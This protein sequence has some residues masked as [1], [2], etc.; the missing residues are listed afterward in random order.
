MQKIKEFF[1]TLLGFNKPVVVDNFKMKSLIEQDIHDFILNVVIADPNERA[2]A[3][4]SALF[5]HLDTYSY[6][7]THALARAF[8]SGTIDYR[9]YEKML[10]RAIELDLKF[11][12]QKITVMEKGMFYTLRPIRN[13]T[14]TQTIV[15]SINAD[16]IMMRTQGEMYDV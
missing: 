4:D 12:A 8:V 1:K 14:E 10:Q 16:F 6:P 13:T 7:Y 11:T 3:I 5:S 9:R 2:Y 15:D